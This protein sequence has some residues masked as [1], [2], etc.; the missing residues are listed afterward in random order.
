MVPRGKMMGFAFAQPILL[1]VWCPIVAAE[2]EFAHGK[3]T[4]AGSSR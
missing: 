2:Q 1:I 4:S 3:E